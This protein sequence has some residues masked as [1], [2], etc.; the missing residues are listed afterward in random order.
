ML[1]LQNVFVNDRKIKTNICVNF[2]TRFTDVWKGND[3][4]K[5]DLGT[6]S[7]LR[8]R[9]MLCYFFIA[10][11]HISQMITASGSWFEDPVI[12]DGKEITTDCIEKYDEGLLEPLQP[13]VWFFMRFASFVGWIAFI[14]CCK[15]PFIA[16]YFYLLANFFYFI[17]CFHI[18]KKNNDES[19]TD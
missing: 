10:I 12:C 14:A 4:C 2:L 5:I 17:Q 18:N 8:T 16:D 9:A 15:W 3:L 7:V 13:M 1:N 19:R 11:L 6:L